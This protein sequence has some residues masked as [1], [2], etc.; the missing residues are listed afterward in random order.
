MA[1][2]ALDLEPIRQ[3]SEHGCSGYGLSC[4]P[5]WNMISDDMSALIA[6]VEKLREGI[7]VAIG[8]IDEVQ[9]QIGR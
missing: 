1:D 7:R 2:E 5:D 9:A 3:R 6:E 8:V 4:D